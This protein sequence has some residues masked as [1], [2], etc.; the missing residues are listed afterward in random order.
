MSQAELSHLSE[1]TKSTT[2]VF[3]R[4]G[5][6]IG[7]EGRCIGWT[8]VAL[9][10]AGTD[11]IEKLA[12]EWRSRIDGIVG[13][14]TDLYASNLRR[15]NQS[16]QIMARVWDLP[17]KLD[18][19]LREIH[20]G[21]WDGQHWS[22]IE[23]TDGARLNAWMER[24]ME[25]APPDG[26]AIPQI[27]ARVSDWLGEVLDP[28]YESSRVILIVSHA[29]WIRIALSQLLKRDTSAMFEIALDHAHATIVLV[30][31]DETRLLVSNVDSIP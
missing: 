5:T 1:A 4:H 2:L 24:W 7:V 14:P 9:S 17:I 18:S 23:A 3:L 6:A 10:D 25:I 15:A 26:E 30:T 27:E 28:E 20:F 29:G 22:A 8:D 11:A 21:Q 12:V 19:R 16:A 31:E 13:R